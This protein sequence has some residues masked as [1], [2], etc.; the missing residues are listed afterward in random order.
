[1]T[2]HS[3]WL[4][5][6]LSQILPSSLPSNERY[7]CKF[8]NFSNFHKFSPNWQKKVGIFGICW[9]ISKIL[10]DSESALKTGQFEHLKTFVARILG[11]RTF[12]AWERK[13]IKLL[14]RHQFP[15]LW[16][17]LNI[18]FWYI[19]QKLWSRQVLNTTYIPYLPPKLS[20]VIK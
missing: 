10:T 11:T 16:N 18:I 1:M 8:F 9:D 15:L 7:F 14:I 20:A 3:L 5:V 4:P 13:N 17:P 6:N 2:S 19:C 12:L